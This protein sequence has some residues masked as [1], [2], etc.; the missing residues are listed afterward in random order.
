M[1][2]PPNLFS[3][4]VAPAHGRFWHCSAERTHIT[5]AAEGQVK[6]EIVPQ[7]PHSGGVRSRPMAP[8][9]SRAARLVRPPKLIGTMNPCSRQ[10]RRTPLWP[11]YSPAAGTLS[12]A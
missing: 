3:H 7:V 10:L 1:N 4:L 9:C 11:R 6:L 2:A 12:E 8:A 5:Q